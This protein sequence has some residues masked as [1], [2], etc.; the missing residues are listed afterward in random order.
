MLVL[1]C[2]IV[3]M[4]DCQ[5]VRL[6]VQ[7]LHDVIYFLTQSMDPLKVLGQNICILFKVL[8]RY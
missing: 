8:S 2:Q 7:I 4:S 6:S 3:S 5:H 1:S